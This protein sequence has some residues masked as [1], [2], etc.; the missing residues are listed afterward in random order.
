MEDG[1]VLWDGVAVDI[2]ER[3]KAEEAL[4]ESEERYRKLFTNMAEEVHFW[5]LVRDES[6]QIK[7]W[8]V[9]DVNPPTLKTWGRKSLEDTVGR[10]ADEIYPGATAHYMPVVQKIMKEGVPYSFEDY[11]PPPVDKYFRFTSVPL[12]D[13]FITTGADIT[14]IK[15]AE[16]ALRKAKDELEERVQQRTEELAKSQQRLQQLA[17][18][19]LLAQEKERK[20]VAVE[21][22]DGLLSELA[23]M[24]MLFEAKMKLL[25]QGNFSDLSEFRKISDIL[26]R[27]IK[28]SRRVMNNLHPSVLDELGL[29]AAM[30]WLCGEY[31]KSYP[32]IVVEKQIE[33]LEQDISDSARVVIF[34]V[35]QEALNNF[36]KHG[37]GDRVDLSLSKSKGSFTLAIRDNGQGFDVEKAQKGL[38]LESMRERVEISGGEFQI[39]SAI[40]QGTKIQATWK[41]L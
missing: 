30:N 18:Q 36:A 4:R 2:T 27:V 19:L 33:V 32:H 34:R 31:Q 21:L 6:G 14:S 1:L 38:G 29:I 9:V 17:S 16:E 13:Y 23:A 7:T 41:I 15:K 39:E 22:H 35:L 5:K 11:F 8:R 10:T 37:K 12:G 40:G 28:E 3:K 26:A 25:E 20:R 24:K